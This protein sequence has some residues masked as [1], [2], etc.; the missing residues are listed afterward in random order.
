MPQRQPPQLAAAAA[1]PTGSALLAP[2]ATTHSCPPV[3]VSQDCSFPHAYTSCCICS[4]PQIKI[5]SALANA[6]QEING[7]LL[8][9]NVIGLRE[10]V[11]SGSHKANNY[12]GSIYMVSCCCCCCA[13]CCLL[14]QDWL[15]RLGGR[16]AKAVCT[17]RLKLVAPARCPSLHDLVR[18]TSGSAPLAES[19]RSSP[20]PHPVSIQIF[21]YMDHDMTGLL[22]RTNRENRKFTAAQVGGWVPRGACWY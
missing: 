4:A 18:P 5:L 15:A 10:I 19:V 12:K 17:W 16:A 21:D 6:P 7:Q 13:S 1:P 22:E 2:F 9:N 14:W 11:R 8:R 20:I 3:K